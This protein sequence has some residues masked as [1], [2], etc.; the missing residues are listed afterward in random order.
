[1]PQH[2]CIQL[3]LPSSGRWIFL[4]FKE[5][6]DKVRV[7]LVESSYCCS[8]DGSG[9]VTPVKNGDGLLQTYRFIFEN[10]LADSPF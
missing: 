4:L 8:D 10:G 2:E 9:M 1:M 7:L 5:T 3:E 6:D